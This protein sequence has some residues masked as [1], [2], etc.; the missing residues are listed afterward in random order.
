[1]AKESIIIDY[2][3]PSLKQES[4]KFIR[5]VPSYTRHYLIQLF[6]IARWI[7][8]YNLVWFVSDLIAGLTVGIVIVPQGMG[9]AKIAQLAPEY[10]L[11]SAF[12]GLIVYCLFATSKDISIGPTAVT[13]L[14]VGQTVTRITTANP[15]ITGPEV[16]VALSLFG[17]M[18]V[19]AVGLLRL[20]IIV[21]FIP[22][23]AIAGFM[24]GSAL[25]I[26]VGQLPKLFG[27]TTVKTQ[28]A[29]YL[30]FGNFLKHLPDTKIDAAFG[31]VS[32]AWLY[33][34]RYVC[35]KLG[36]KY[37]K[38]ATHLF[39]F[40]IMRNG[41][42][43]IFG[44]LLA[45][46]INIGKETSPISILKT[47]PP[48]FQQ[49]GVP[50]V[51]SNVISEVMGSLPSLCIVLIL[52]HV[53]VAKAFGRIND[54]VV[55]PD[56]EIIAIGFSNIWASFFGAFPS[57]GS[58]SRTAIFA[59][60]GVKTPL[61]GIFSALVV[62]L[63]LY[64]L[65]PAFFYIPD[66]VLAA[67]IIHAVADLVSAPS[68]L[69]R[70]ASI[71]LWEL[72]VYIV[73]V[74]VIVFWTVEG[75]IYASLGVS[76]VILLYRIARPR[77][78]T[79]GRIPLSSDSALLSDD[80]DQT[81]KMVDSQNYLYVPEDHPVLGNLVESLPPG[82][83]MCRVDES[84]TY[85]NSSFISDKIINYCKT[86]SRKG[87]AVL[88]KGD[89]NWNEDASPALISARAKLPLLHAVILD[90]AS[91]NQMDSSG[92]QAI[93][94]IQ[95]AL[96]R[97]SGRPVEFH[98]VNIANSS[99]R[100]SLIIAE[101]GNQ[102]RAGDEILSDSKRDRDSGCTVDEEKRVTCEE[103]ASCASSNNDRGITLPKDRYPFFHL[104]ADMAVR[105]A[106]ETISLRDDPPNQSV[107]TLNSLASLD[108][109]SH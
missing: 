12:V 27:I 93:V 108:S 61:A 84:F 46:L 99:I 82:I 101:F 41:I 95:V 17:G 28:A 34:V 89:M 23:P 86:N 109:T 32:L 18:I 45:F 33:A 96:N 1:M 44:T 81:K 73:T 71:S 76:V 2:E 5:N 29:V 53:A 100:R 106:L 47:V 67:I 70:L 10:G 60:S 97:Y 78:N 72:L 104:S 19:M 4:K 49:M 103:Y 31:L 55:T 59:R 65:T 43:I 56:Q 37:P 74:A 57:T 77:F 20:G 52:E 75:G 48:G 38:Y 83:L 94:D 35:Q 8:R 88:K 25:T 22:A 24:T 62:L 7:H 13:A 66:S 92:L 39:F 14:L 51:K 58:F 3:E 91:V 102:S 21:D 40:N 87:A 63:A 64:A 98:F 16:A 79:L 30:V 42:L 68:Y 105:S 50:Q 69:I 107:D 36:Q 85:P 26:S 11:Y 90:F 6:P 9:Y 15:D 54:Y 80:D